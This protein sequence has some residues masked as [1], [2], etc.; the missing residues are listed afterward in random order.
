LI[1]VDL[2]LSQ[3]RNGRSPDRRRRGQEEKYF[4]NYELTSG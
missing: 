1:I 3:R 4:I 2:F